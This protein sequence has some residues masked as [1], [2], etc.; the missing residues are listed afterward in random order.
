MRF[1]KFF[2][3]GGSPNPL[4]PSGR[5]LQSFSEYHPFQRLWCYFNFFAP[6][7]FI[8]SRRLWSPSHVVCIALRRGALI[9]TRRNIS[10]SLMTKCGYMNIAPYVDIHVNSMQAVGADPTS[11]ENTWQMRHT[12]YDDQTAT[13]DTLSI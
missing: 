7:T 6:A 11:L 9:A 1:Y 10:S 2:S 12:E 3:R 5:G 8:K 4:T 13:Q